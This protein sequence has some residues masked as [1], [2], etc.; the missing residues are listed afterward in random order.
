MTSNLRGVPHWGQ[1]GYLP[2]MDELDPVSRARSPYSISITELVVS[3]GVTEHR[4]GLLRGFL[5][6][7]RALHE[8]GTERGFQWVDGSFTQDIE[9]AGGRVPNDIDVVTFF[10]IPEGYSAEE[11]V[12]GFPSLFDR[13][14]MKD[15]Y[16]VDSYYA[17][18]NQTTSEETVSESAY[19]YSLWSH[20]KGGRWKGYLTVDMSD[21]DDEALLRLHELITEAGG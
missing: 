17:Q 6:F 5:E 16:S 2:P 3:F 9:T 13:Q 4:R 1:D 7:R 11:F 21:N 15:L 8:A 20:T 12:R 14:N 19:W 10:Y 18:L